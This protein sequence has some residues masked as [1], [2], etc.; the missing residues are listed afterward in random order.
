MKE[1]IRKA[2]HNKSN[3]RRRQRQRENGCRQ[4]DTERKRGK[5]K[6]DQKR[7]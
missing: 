3:Q 7:R 6:T 4:E 1:G 5:M 2:K